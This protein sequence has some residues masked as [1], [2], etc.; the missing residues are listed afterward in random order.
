[1]VCYDKLGRKAE[2]I[3]VYNQ[4]RKMLSA[5]LG[6]LPSSEVERIYKTIKGEHAVA[7]A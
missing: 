4:C 3:S 5:K 7:K 6:I 1:M 2:A